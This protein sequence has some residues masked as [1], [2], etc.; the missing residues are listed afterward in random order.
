LLRAD[1]SLETLDEGGGLIGVGGL[2]AFNEGEMSM[3]PGDRLY[4][5]SDG[6]TE[7]S[8]GPFELFGEGRFFRKLQELKKRDLDLVCEKMI[9]ALH[10]FGRARPIK[11]DI[12][13]LGIEYRGRSL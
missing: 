9:E 13:L 5:Y 11:D 6:I 1:G 10:A 7:H 2:G 12:T 3:R 8:N 4:L